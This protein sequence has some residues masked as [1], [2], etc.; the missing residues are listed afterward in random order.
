MLVG[1][2]A[3]LRFGFNDKTLTQLDLELLHLVVVQVFLDEV[4]FPFDPS[5]HLGWHI[6]D[7]PGH[8]ELHHKHHVLMGKED[9]F[10]QSIPLSHTHLMKYTG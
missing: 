2:S 1:G 6:R 5:L 4:T 3:D 7:Q 10:I 9:V 8:K